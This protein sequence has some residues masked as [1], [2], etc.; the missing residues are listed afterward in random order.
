[1]RSSISLLS[2][3]G[4]AR[5]AGEQPGLRPQAAPAGRFRR[6]RGSG[7]WIGGVKLLAALSA[8]GQHQT[9]FV[10]ELRQRLAIPDA[11]ADAWCPRCDGGFS[12][13]GRVTRARRALRTAQLLSFAMSRRR[14]PE[15]ALWQRFAVPAF[16]T[17]LRENEF[18]PSF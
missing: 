17:A 10:A 14:R 3:H 8:T 16:D 2:L 18:L 11:A 12:G 1:M 13:R 4:G 7:V 6:G 15:A 9:I 5:D